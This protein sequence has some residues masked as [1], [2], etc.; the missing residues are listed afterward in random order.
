MA[1]LDALLR[2]VARAWAWAWAWARESKIARTVDEKRNA[3]S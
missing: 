1:R 3:Q 2:L